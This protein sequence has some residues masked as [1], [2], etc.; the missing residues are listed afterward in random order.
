[1]RNAN[2]RQV[3]DAYGQV[4]DFDEVLINACPPARRRELQ[5]EAEILIQAFGRA[6]DPEALQRMAATLT[7]DAEQ[8]QSDRVHARRLAAV[9]R[10]RAKAIPTAKA[11]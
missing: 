11:S 9:L 5:A 2:K 6:D 7:R 1:M 4:I 10:L 3:E 8:N